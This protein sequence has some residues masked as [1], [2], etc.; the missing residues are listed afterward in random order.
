MRVRADGVGEA[1]AERPLEAG[2]ELDP[3]EAADAEIPIQHVVERDAAAYRRGA[4]LSHED[5]DEREDVLL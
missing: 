5:V 1:H 4:Q 3:F 2:E